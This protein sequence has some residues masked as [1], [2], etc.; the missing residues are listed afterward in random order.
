MTD[1]GDHPNFSNL[2]TSHPR[3]PS[4]KMAAATAQS[5][6]SGEAGRGIGRAADAS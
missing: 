2:M 4:R 5:P 1:S 3:P 6:A